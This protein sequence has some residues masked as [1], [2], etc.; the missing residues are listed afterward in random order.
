MIDI[1][2]EEIRRLS[3][4]E[5]MTD[6]EIALMIGVHRVTVSRIRKKYKMPKAVLSNRKDK[7]VHCTKCRKPFIIRRREKDTK[8]HYK[9][10]DCKS[11]QTTT[12][13]CQF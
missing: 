7:R 1:G 4:D 13:K 6:K 10:D 11:L 2:V 8:G 12:S 3:S 5:G 9:C